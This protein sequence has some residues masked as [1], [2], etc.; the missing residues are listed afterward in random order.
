MDP[1]RAIGRR[2]TRADVP[3]LVATIGLAFADDPVWG[4][5]FARAG[6][7]AEPLWRLFI[8][9]A[10]RHDWVWSTDAAGAVAIWIPPGETELSDEQEATL[11]RAAGEIL[12]PEGAAYL[13]EV[14]LA[15]ATAHPQD[16]PHYYL[17]LLG[18]HPA[19]RGHGIGMRLLAQNLASIDLERR[20]AYL[21]SSNPANNLR[22]EGVGFRPIGRF[23]LPADGPVVTTMWRPAG[24]ALS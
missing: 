8:E 11:A 18:T 10:L 3:A 5:V 9:G 4:R 24:G 23:S 6:D 20:P 14:M 22:Y 13:D 12:G 15:F 19:Q 1:D 7:R 17:S 16:E 21:E 2:A